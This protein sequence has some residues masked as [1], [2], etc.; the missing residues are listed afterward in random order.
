[1]S[2]PGNWQ[3]ADRQRRLLSSIRGDPAQVR[4]ALRLRVLSPLD[5]LRYVAQIAPRPLL[6]VNGR[7]DNVVPLWSGRQL[8]AR[9]RARTN[10]LRLQRRPR[11][12]RRPEWAGATAEAIASFVLVHVVEPTFGV[13]RH[14]NGT[15]WQPAAN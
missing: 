10:R 3:A 2:T 12:A 14:P 15:Y 9:G 11:S 13:S 7:Q 1:M 5:P 4:S 6:I 8:Q